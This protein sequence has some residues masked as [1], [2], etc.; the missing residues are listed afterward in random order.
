MGVGELRLLRPQTF[1]GAGK[2]KVAI[3]LDLGVSPGMTNYNSS[4]EEH[5]LNPG[6]EGFP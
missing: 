3:G 4:L 6:I 5:A 1:W 2:A